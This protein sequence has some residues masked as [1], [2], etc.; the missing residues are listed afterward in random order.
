MVG[1]EN[2]EES[3]KGS[4]ILTNQAEKAGHN[5]FIENF[6]LE[7]KSASV[8]K[9]NGYKRF[10]SW[11]QINENSSE[12]Q[13]SFVDPLTTPGAET[14]FILL[15]GRRDET[16]YQTQ[17]KYKWLG[18]QA[19]LSEGGN[20]HDNY[21][22]S[23]ILN[24][25]NLEELSKTTLKVDL[26]GMNFYIYKYMRLPVL[27][28]VGGDSFKQLQMVSRNDALGESDQNPDPDASE[29][30]NQVNSSRPTDSAANSSPVSDPRNQKKNEF[31]SG[32]YVVGGIEYTYTNPG[33][34]KQ[35]LTLIRREWPI[36]AKNKSQ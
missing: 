18:K 28:Y 10:G 14:E 8:W 27:L 33:P 36:P 4:L 26:A 7:N 32:Y 9:N 23:K 29:P 16:I 20:V 11:Y 5:I 19:T 25:Q 35:S 22:F 34:V 24:H 1:A 17:V 31:L 30:F 21:Q 2:A 6:S 12:L 13:E 15:K 3:V